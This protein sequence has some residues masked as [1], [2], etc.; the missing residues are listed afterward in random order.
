MGCL[1]W[2]RASRADLHCKKTLILLNM[3]N[4]Q[5]CVPLCNDRGGYR[6]PWKDKNRLKL[7]TYAI[8]RAMPKSPSKIWTPGEYAVVCKD[9]FDENDYT[10]QTYYGM[11][12]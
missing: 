3:P 4:T 12:F 1:P 6:F 5:C 10:T 2:I 8:K 11:L 9:H 7:W